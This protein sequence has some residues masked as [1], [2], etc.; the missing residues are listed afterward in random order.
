MSSF[1]SEPLAAADASGRGEV[2]PALS[3]RLLHHR[4]R[5]HEGV[6]TMAPPG[7][8]LAGALALGD[9][10]LDEDTQ[11]DAGLCRIEWH[12]RRWLL[13]NGSRSLVCALNG[14]RVMAG[15]TVPIGG[16][17]D[18]LEIGLTRFGVE[19]RT[20]TAADAAAEPQAFEAAES[21][22]AA[23]PDFDLRELATEQ[24][25]PASSRPFDDPFGVLQDD[26]RRAE[27]AEKT[28][29]GLLDESPRP[30][31]PHAQRQAGTARGAK[32]QPQNQSDPEAE[33]LIGLP[34]A[35]ASQQKLFDD[36]HEEFF[37]VVRDPLQLAGIAWAPGDIL[38]GGQHAEPTEEPEHDAQPYVTPFDLLKA[39]ESINQLIDGFD[40]LGPAPTLDFEAKDEVLL[41]F[42]PE[43]SQRPKPVPSLTRRDHHATSPDSHMPVPRAR[44]AD[45]EPG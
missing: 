36:L 8:S 39:R 31:A 33:G 29:A 26:S 25:A 18:V 7:A 30:P 3:L 24:G 38:P 27:S 10:A 21:M 28:L 35:S 17:G 22:D 14:E 1:T 15:T 41:L 42:A 43:L 12:G 37:R 4:G 45:E 6:V 11:R 40:P 9:G 32:N 44:A 34:D 5:V 13:S 20:E 16:P 23:V 19:A 2:T